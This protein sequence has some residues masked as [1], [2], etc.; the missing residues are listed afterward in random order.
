MKK[1]VFLLVVSNRLIDVKFLNVYGNTF[2]LLNIGKKF[3]TI[4]S[5]F[6]AKKNLISALMLEF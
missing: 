6:G 5:L 4:I 2:L 3:V 1:I